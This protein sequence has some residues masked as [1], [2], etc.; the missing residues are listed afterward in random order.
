VPRRALHIV[1]QEGGPAGLFLPPLIERGF[2]IVDVVPS[3]TP[4][5]ESIDGFHAVLSCGGTVNADQEAEHPWLRTE[6]GLL[7]D[8]VRAGVPVMGLCLGAQLLAQAVGGAVYRCQPPEVGWF[9]V[10]TAPE[11][12]SDPVMAAMPDRFRALQ[13]HYYACE[14][15][16]S[17]TVLATS[18][19]CVQAFRAA[20]AAWGTQFHIEATRDTLREWGESAPE[21]LEAAGYPRERYLAELDEYHV[22]HE[23][24]GRGMAQRF[25]DVALAY[26]EGAAPV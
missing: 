20:P 13:W 21:E 14:L 16:A 26:A 5:P 2:E 12:A 11:A 24:V 1:N 15:P 23:A 17:A 3:R 6:V 4:L 9:S 19:V 7:R 8:A 18:P 10:D 22:T 25:A